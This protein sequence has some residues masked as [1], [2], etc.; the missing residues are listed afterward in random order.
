MGRKKI[1]SYGFSIAT[2]EGIT[3]STGY[4]KLNSEII[5]YD[6][7]TNT[8][9]GIGQR[10][11][12]GSLITTHA[13]N[14]LMRK[15]E[16]NGLSLTGI[17]T[18]HNMPNTDL[19]QSKKDIDNYYLEIPRG[20]GRPNLQDRSSGD[21]QAGFTEERSGGGSNIHAS[22]NIQFIS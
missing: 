3:T 14:S 4:V 13:V 6:S 19:L 17:N 7:I 21:N 5:Y 22:K 9:L 8:G 11:V 20:A 10:G 12:D 16:F 18:S 1:E 15:Y 2:F